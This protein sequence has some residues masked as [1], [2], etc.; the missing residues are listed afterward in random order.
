MGPRGVTGR[1]VL[2]NSAWARLNDARVD[3]SR[4][5]E[6]ADGM[7]AGIVWASTVLCLEAGYSARDA[8]A[9]GLL[10]RGFMRLP[11]APVNEQASNRALVLQAQLAAVGHHRVPPSDLLTAAIAEQH[12]LT[13]L[14][15]DKDFDV[16]LDKTDCAAA[17]EWLVP[18]GTL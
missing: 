12:A 18:R 5:A 17:A 6:I 8:E 1:Y 2:D 16:I 7:D 3:E 9:H 11:L 13:I 10:M 4:I 15:Y 14:H